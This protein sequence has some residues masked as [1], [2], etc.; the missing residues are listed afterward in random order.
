[1]LICPIHILNPQKR[2]QDLYIVSSMAQHSADKHVAQLGH[3]ILIPSQP[4]FTLT[5]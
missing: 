4:D 3:I 1:M 2:V 5:P